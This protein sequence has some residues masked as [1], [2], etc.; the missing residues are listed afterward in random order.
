M[1]RVE[2]AADSTRVYATEVYAVGN[3]VSADYTKYATLKIGTNITG[4]AVTVDFNAGSLRL[5]VASTAAVN[6]VVR[7]VGVVA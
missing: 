7:R 1:V 2:D 3:G 4:L 6:V 5:R